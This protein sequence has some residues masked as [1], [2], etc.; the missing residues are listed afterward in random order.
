MKNGMLFF[1]YKKILLA[2]LALL[3]LILNACQGDNQEDVPFR[4]VNIDINLSSPDFI[5]LNGVGGFVYI[6]GGVKGIFVSRK[7]FDEYVA[8][9]RNCTFNAQDGCVVSADSSGFFLEDR[10]CCGSRFSF[11][12]GNSINGPATRTLRIYR[13][14]ITGTTLSITN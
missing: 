8:F 5:A 14:F 6:S 1:L 7:S 12:Q 2:N 10:A 3:F 4:T 11:D 13:T 9:D